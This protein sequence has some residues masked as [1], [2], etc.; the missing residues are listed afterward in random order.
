MIS[1]R[2]CPVG[3]PS[4]TCIDGCIVSI[5]CYSSHDLNSGYFF[6]L[7]KTPFID[8][9][10]VHDLKTRQV[11]YSDPLCICL[12]GVVKP[13]PGNFLGSPK[14]RMFFCRSVA[15][16]RSQAEQ[17]GCPVLLLERGVHR[18]RHHHCHQICILRRSMCINVTQNF[19]TLFTLR[20]SLKVEK[21]SGNHN[22]SYF[23]GNPQSTKELLI[24]I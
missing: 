19:P 6:L 21:C 16:R 22:V 2:Y 17:V 7:F 1:L 13:C 23:E 11:H 4:V 10:N 14:R 20:N 12:G 15:Q 24:G 8:W 5:N 9:T 3:E 18:H